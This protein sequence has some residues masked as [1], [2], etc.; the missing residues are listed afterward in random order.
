[1][2]KRP[3]PT[4]TQFMLSHTW[5]GIAAIIGTIITVITIGIY[6]AVLSVSKKHAL[7]AHGPAGAGLDYIIMR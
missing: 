6:Y 4:H 5:E 3:P 7:T 2:G 1:M